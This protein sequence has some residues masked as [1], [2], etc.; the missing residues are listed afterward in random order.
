MRVSKNERLRLLVT[1]ASGV[2]GAYFARHALDLG[3]DVFSIRHNDRPHTT[4]TALGIAD[5]ITWARGDILDTEFL[6][7]LLAEHDIQGIAHFAAKP[8]VRTGTTAGKPIYQVNAMGTVALLEAVKHVVASR[9]VHFLMV[10][11]VTGDTPLLVEMD[12]E[13]HRV[14]MADVWERYARTPLVGADREQVPT[15]GLRCLDIVDGKTVFSEA[16]AIVRHKTREEVRRIHYGGAYVDM[17]IGH[18]A[19]VFA[20]DGTVKPTKVSDLREG[21]LLVVPAAS[22]HAV[23]SVDD[24][25]PYLLDLLSTPAKE[26]LGAARKNVTRHRLGKVRLRDPGV[27]EMVGTY[28]ADGYADDYRVTFV[29]N[30]TTKLVVYNKVK[31]LLRSLEFHTNEE[32]RGGPKQTVSLSVNSLELATLLSDMMGTLARDKRLRGSWAWNLDREAVLRF[33]EGYRCDS[34]QL[35][36]GGLR[37]TTASRELATDLMWLYSLADLCP[38]MHHVTDEYIAARTPGRIDGREIRGGGFWFVRVPIGALNRGKGC[39]TPAAKCLPVSY[40]RKALDGTS[41]GHEL[42][43]RLS[44]KK[45]IGLERLADE[46]PAIFGDVSMGCVAVQK[47]ETVA[48]SAY[49]FDINCPISGSFCAGIRPIKARNTD[50]TYGDAGD[51]PYSEDMPL[52]GTSIYETSKISAEVACRAYQAHGWVPDL[53]ISRSCNIVGVDFSWRL[54]GNTIRQFL[55]GAPAK[56]YSKNQYVREYLDCESAVEAQMQLLLRAD[57]HRGEAFNIGGGEQYTQEEMIEKIRRDHFP[58]GHTIRI[59][60]PAGHMI[61]I[62]YQRMDCAKIQRALGWRPRRDVAQAIANVVTF[63]RA[64]KELAPWSLL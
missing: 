50:K 43:G 62:A 2:Y 56:I 17:T 16:E 14:T 28:L 45:T 61:E 29:C 51:R 27:L 57:E 63:W 42:R 23:P 53:V 35:P 3:H 24:Y 34:Y 37:F 40:V 13:R 6:S 32:D 8:L 44:S 4:A 20:G 18:S 39:R 49:V 19:F 47:I 1:G 22:R 7:L 64:H 31:E 33:I 46:F 55:S 26:R 41:I 25:N 9:P 15:P 12:G 5:R 11:S 54:V 38:L 30:K 36:D 21:D 59:A 60:P 10:S 48:P 58:E 52:M